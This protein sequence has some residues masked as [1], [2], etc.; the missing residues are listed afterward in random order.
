[1]STG[2][3]QKLAIAR[4]LIRNPRILIL[5][6]AITGFDVDSEIKLNEA[7]PDIALGRTVIIVSN[8]LWYLRLCNRIFVLDNGKI[9]QEGSFESLKETAGF[10]SETYAKQMSVLGVKQTN[11]T[12]KKA[13]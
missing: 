6:D 9:T 12:I 13:S 10:F 4:A 11:K 8:R 1:M 7:L 2:L 5:D 3:R